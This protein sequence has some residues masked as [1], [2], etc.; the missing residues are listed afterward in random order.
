MDLKKITEALRH[1]HDR[2][3]RVEAEKAWET[4]WTRR[5]WITSITFAVAVIWLTIIHEPVAFA[6]AL[7][8]AAGYL[9]STLTLPMIKSGW[10]ARYEKK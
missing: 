4:S 9:L 5:W 7:V 1:L 10:I 8:P 3:R 6:K 2:N